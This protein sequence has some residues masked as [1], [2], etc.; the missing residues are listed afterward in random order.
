MKSGWTFRI[1]ACLMVIFFQ[2][3][4]LAGQMKPEGHTVRLNGM[5]MYYETCGEGEPLVLLHGFTGTGRSWAPFIDSLGAH[6]RLIIPD[7][8]GHGGSTNPAGVFTH[9]QSALDIYALL[10]SLGINKFSG[11]GSSSGGMTLLH[12]ATQKPGRA[13]ALILIGATIYFP[14]QARVIM[15]GRD[16]DSIPT[17]RI[18]SMRKAHT[19]GDSQIRTL[20][21]NFYDF[22][23][24]YE[25]MNF[26]GPLLSTIQ[27]RTL[28]V[29][30]DRD[31][32]FPVEI[33]LRMY[34][35]IPR[36]YLWIVPNGGHGPVG[37]D[38]RPVFTRTALDF[39]G[40]RWEKK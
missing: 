6:Y 7:M 25:D 35:S 14:E 1:F 29:H 5:E 40:G 38:M 19:H 36:S 15:R 20:L 12:M 2:S 18:E 16:P 31:E 17:E 24:S 30:G 32:Y 28:I 11:I 8:R 34:E 21:Q 10:D 23:I 4:F 13:E 22:R 9:R 3:R 37:G 26:T 27:A 33:P 39:L